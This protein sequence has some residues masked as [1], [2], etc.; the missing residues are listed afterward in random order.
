MPSAPPLSFPTLSPV[1][2][3]AGQHLGDIGPTMDPAVLGLPPGAADT[4]M[5]DLSV[6]PYRAMDPHAGGIPPCPPRAVDPGYMPHLVHGHNHAQHPMAPM[7]YLGSGPIGAFGNAGGTGAHTPGYTYGRIESVSDLVSSTSPDFEY[8][9]EFGAIL[10]AGK[11]HECVQFA[12]HIIT[13]ANR[14]KFLSAATAHNGAST[15]PLRAEIKRLTTEALAAAKELQELRD[16]LKSSQELT[17][18]LKAQRD[19]SHKRHDDALAEQRPLLQCVRDLEQELSSASRRRPGSPTR[20]HHQRSPP[21]AGH[22]TT[23]PCSRPRPGRAEQ[24]RGRRQTQGS[25]ILEPDTGDVIMASFP[26]G[27]QPMRMHP[28]QPNYANKRPC[29]VTN[30]RWRTDGGIEVIGL[31]R[32]K[33]GT[34]YIPSTLGIGWHALENGART[35]KE[36]YRR[37]NLL[38]RNRQ[39]EIWLAAARSAFEFRRLAEPI[40]E[41]MAHLLRLGALRKSV[42]TIIN[43]GI[44]HGA[45][46]S[47]AS[48]G[49]RLH[50]GGYG[51][52]YTP[53]VQLWAV[54]HAATDVDSTKLTATTGRTVTAADLRRAIKDA[55]YSDV[56]FGITPAELAGGVYKLP[57][58]AHYDGSLDVGNVVQWLRAN[59][60]T[61]YMVHA[62]FRPFLRRVDEVSSGG[63]RRAFSPDDLLPGESL[64]PEANEALADFTADCEWTPSRGPRRPLSP[65]TSA[66]VPTDDSASPETS[67]ATPLPEDTEMLGA[68]IPP[69]SSGAAVSS[70]P[71]A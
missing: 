14:A 12:M 33:A 15:G 54:I 37:I 38:F 71:A 42:W 46:F 53:D 51:G 62:H 8:S 69:A 10:H 21:R 32:T 45:D 57:R 3:T 18:A 56:H 70:E 35:T 25:A 2:H 68:E 50:S 64:A 28:E 1:D 26:A 59:G 7:P 44:R 40:P 66:A 5:E 11:C 22:R 49:C 13:P 34:P 4:T 43:D 9:P 48:P 63:Y 47:I 24:V 16:A 36:V 29:S 58:L 55:L 17:T 31:P 67:V 52:L 27:I 6:A 39:E 19:A 30:Y 23:T 61:S 41:V 65:I 60:M 20:G